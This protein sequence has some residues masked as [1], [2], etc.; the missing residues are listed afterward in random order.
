MRNLHLPFA[1]IALTLA[2][3]AVAGEDPPESVRI[4]PA[5]LAPNRWYEISQA[6]T[7]PQWWS[8][9]WLVPD[10]GEVVIWGKVGGHRDESKW[11]DVNTL[12]LD[13][14]VPEW[15]ESFPQGK[16]EAWADGKFPNWGCACHR[17]RHEP[18]RP[19]LTDINDDWIGS[20]KTNVVR[21][22]ETD[23]VLRPTR[24]PTFD[25]G[26]VDTK[27]NRI[28]YYVGGQTF[29][30]EPASRTW[31]DLKAA[32]PTALDGLVMGMMAYDPVA[33]KVVLFGGSYGL[34]PWGGAR[35]WI[36]DC[37]KN[38]WRRADVEPTHVSES[39]RALDRARKN[40]GGV[41]YAAQYLDRYDEDVNRQIT[42]EAE[43]LGQQ[44]QNASDK[45]EEA[46]QHVEED[47][48]RDRLRTA[49]ELAAT[50][51][52]RQAD[53]ARLMA[54]G[55]AA[56]AVAP[57]SQAAERL[58]EA[59][60]ELRS[61]PPLRS[62]A[63]LVYDRENELFVLFGGDAQDRFLADTWVFDPA[64]ER[65]T[66]RRPEVSPPPVD[67][68]AACYL[69]KP[70]LVF[71]TTLST[72]RTEGRAWVYDTAENTWTPLN[73]QLPR[74][75]MAWASAAY[76]AKHDLI[77][78]TSPQRGTWVGRVDPADIDEG[79]EGVPPGTWAWNSRG[80]AQMESILGAPEPDPEAVREKLAELPANTYVSADYPGHLT[81]K[82]WSSTTFDTDR[83]MVLYTG[84]GHSGY[85]GEDIA[86]YDTSTNRWHFQ[87][88]PAFI[89]LLHNYNGAL[90]GWTYGFRPTSQHTYLWYAYD[91]T[92]RTMLYCARSLGIRNGMQVLLEDDDSK[93]FEYDQNTH[94]TFTWVYDTVR[95]R[96]YPPVPGRPFGT[97][98]SMALIGTPNGIYAKIGRTLWHCEVT[99][100]DGRADLK[101]TVVD[102][103]SPSGWGEFQPL[104]Y[105][106]RR[107]RL[108][109]T[110]VAARGEPVRVWEWPLDG[111][112]WNELEVTGNRNWY[113]R[114]VVYDDAN[115]ALI[116]M[117]SQQLMVMNCETNEWK[118]LDIEMPEGSYGTECALEYDPVNK[119]LVALIPVR[120]S[121]RMQVGLIRYDPETA[122][123]KQD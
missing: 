110:A 99:T 55:N 59:I 112:P 109:M 30:Y 11:Y 29:A 64:T 36:F 63:V 24:A 81:S 45:I 10:T 111:G 77:V 1:L 103:G 51:L 42:T 119:V 83:G 48:D 118:E 18:D 82:T 62:N 13:D 19:W 117:P 33:D 52:E 108:L 41:A 85:K 39:R 87:G 86:L 35:T 80:R 79:A 97:T 107:N 53:G 8:S 46:L 43:E 115:D 113:S 93:A 31:T 116:A 68:Y 44:I 37:E 50:A 22:V 105:D 123:Y 25:Q 74:S 9:A 57:L 73:F 122:R 47:R 26:A 92:S 60:E 66:E 3:G 21:I 14:E 76:S 75:R 58:K 15:K 106:S 56:E 72:H 20:G 100:E 49:G 32:P 16:E 17:L 34:N 102:D 120:F 96:L 91:P 101:W 104:M 38:E 84:G 12:S 90:F 78:L 88:P 7:A 94:R 6:Q 54:A 4:N 69:D 5:D 89:P 70:G 65:W 98:W 28:V 95:N 40:A 23:G 2:A 114:E 67:I 121:G 61:E 27:R 71:L